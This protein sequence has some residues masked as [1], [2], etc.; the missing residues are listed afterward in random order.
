ME[1]VTRN[2]VW[3][4]MLWHAGRSIM[5]LVLISTLSFHMLYVVMIITWTRMGVHTIYEQVRGLRT[6]L[7]ECLI[8][9]S[10]PLLFSSS[11]QFR[12]YGESRPSQR[13]E[14]RGLGQGFSCHCHKQHWCYCQN[15]CLHLSK[16]YVWEGEDD[17]RFNQS[18]LCILLI[19]AHIQTV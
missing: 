15:V 9:S 13:C 12:S 18:Y 1:E 16:L 11:S 14:G 19:V 7:L 6:R 8:L 5:C 2:L 3:V 17:C 4:V 10:S